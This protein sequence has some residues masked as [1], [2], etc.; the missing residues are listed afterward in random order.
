MMKPLAHTYRRRLHEE[1]VG[2]YGYVTTATARELGIPGIELVKLHR[3]G[4]L[5]RVGHGVYRFDDIPQTDQGA[6]M[7][8]VLMAGPDAVLIGDAVLS[9]LDLG[10]ANPRRIR[11]ATP[12]RVQR[13]LPT[14]LDVKQMRIGLE[15]LTAIEGIPA[16]TLRRAIRD[17]RGTIMDERLLDAVREGRRRGL[18]TRGDATALEAELGALPGVT[19]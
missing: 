7:E 18:L 13:T 11:I 9:L 19:E 15:D 5:T 16:T 17:C 3:R 14:R 8:A 2:N 1:A 4:G 12:R 10:L 6:Y